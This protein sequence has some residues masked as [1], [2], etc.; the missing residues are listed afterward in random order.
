MRKT[1]KSNIFTGDS[2][3]MKRISNYL[4]LALFAFVI[5]TSVISCSNDE[6]FGL[7]DE[8]SYDF[9]SDSFNQ[10]DYSSHSYL[11]F[12]KEKKVYSDIDY[13]IIASALNRIVAS[14]LD[15][16]I[17]IKKNDYNSLNMS[18]EL[19]GICV[20][21]INHTNYIVYDRIKQ[22]KHN[23]KK[24]IYYTNNIHVDISKFHIYRNYLTGLLFFCRRNYFEPM[25]HNTASRYGYCHLHR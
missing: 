18:R 10:F 4:K 7:E 8:I 16:S 23:D 15:G 5:S 17:Q 1:N 6:F 22:Q 19:Y 21:M 25:Q 2:T 9:Y 24:S 3:T 11:T 20:D 12:D 13:E 14:N